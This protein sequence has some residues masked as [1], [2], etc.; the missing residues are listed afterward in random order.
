MYTDNLR[1]KNVMMTS[2][3]AG[4]VYRNAKLEDFQSRINLFKDDAELHLLLAQI[5]EES[6]RLEEISAS[7]QVS[8]PFHGQLSQLWSSHLA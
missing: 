6:R 3:E 7:Q 2:L 1:M 5:A 4:Q 8:H